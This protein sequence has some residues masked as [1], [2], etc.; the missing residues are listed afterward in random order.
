MSRFLIWLVNGK[1]VR[2]HGCDMFRKCIVAEQNKHILHE[3]GNK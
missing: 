2:V 1:F 3:S